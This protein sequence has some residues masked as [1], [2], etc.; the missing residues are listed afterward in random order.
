MTRDYKTELELTEIEPGHWVYQPVP[1]RRVTD[2]SRREALNLV[3]RVQRKNNGSQ[4]HIFDCAYYSFYW[5]R[6]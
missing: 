6:P 5:K 2:E 4:T 3:D 1:W